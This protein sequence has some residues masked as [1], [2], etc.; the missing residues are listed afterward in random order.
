MK[1]R[2]TR[3]GA[4]G[5]ALGLLSA[6]V[7]SPAAAKTVTK[8]K[9]FSQCLSTSSPLTDLTTAS[10]SQFVSVPKNGKKVQPG[11]VTAVRTAGARIP[12]TYVGDLALTLVSPAGRA[13]P[14]EVIRDQEADGLGTGAA[15]CA[16]SLV[17]FGDAF[18]TP[19][20]S[21]DAQTTSDAPITGSFKPE[22][23]LAGFVGGPA[24]GFW[25]LVVSDGFFDD[26]GAL[27][28]FSLDLT[29]SYKKPVKKKGEK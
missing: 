16:G 22:Q 21:I 7:A 9:T 13:V 23:P 2:L 12:H 6:A 27:N 25:T 18:A 24:R 17:L 8:T 4:L 28:A 5:L 11:T 14:L 19:I 10:A 1:R 29:F 15:S 26:S 3:L 20:S